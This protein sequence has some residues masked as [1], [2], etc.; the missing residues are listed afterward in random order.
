MIA[1]DTAIPVPPEMNART[2]GIFWMRGAA[3]STLQLSLPAPCG[4]KQN[5][6]TFPSL[7]L[8]GGCAKHARLRG[9]LDKQKGSIA[10]DHDADLVVWQSGRRLQ[11]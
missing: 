4:P 2:G 9:G 5:A 3:I 8:L 1:T 6:A 10:T 11:S 7:I